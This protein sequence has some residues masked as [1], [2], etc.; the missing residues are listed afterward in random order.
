LKT[1]TVNG[2]REIKQVEVTEGSKGSSPARRG[3]GNA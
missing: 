2:S 3:V 1:E